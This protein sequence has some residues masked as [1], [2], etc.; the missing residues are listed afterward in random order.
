MVFRSHLRLL[1]PGWIGQCS[2][3]YDCAIFLIL[4][5]K[6]PYRLKDVSVAT[7]A[8]SERNLKNELHYFHDTVG[9]LKARIENNY[10]Y[11]VVDCDT[12][13]TVDCEVLVS[14]NEIQCCNCKELQ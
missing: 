7:M 2:V 1:M 5:S 14:E 6:Y 10:L 8:L 11:P 3:L 12:I 13:R 9:N 4:Y